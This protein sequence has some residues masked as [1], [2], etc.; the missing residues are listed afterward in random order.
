M[1]YRRFGG[2]LQSSGWKVWTRYLLSSD[3]VRR[4]GRAQ[5]GEG[6]GEESVGD[7][8]Q[9]LSYSI[10]E[11]AGARTVLCL[12]QAKAALEP[13]HSRPNNDQWSLPRSSFFFFLPYRRASQLLQ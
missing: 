3:G 10:R 12:L 9:S 4:R 2:E 6:K 8:L 1:A 7:R 5:K 13:G 11:R